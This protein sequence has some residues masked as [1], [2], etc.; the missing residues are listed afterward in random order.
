SRKRMAP[1]SSGRPCKTSARRR[2]SSLSEPLLA[3]LRSAPTLAL[4]RRPSRRALPPSASHSEALPRLQQPAASWPKGN[5]L[6]A[7]P[8]CVRLTQYEAMS[9]DGQETLDRCD[10]CVSGLRVGRRRRRRHDEKRATD[11]GHGHHHEGEGRAR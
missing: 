7:R 2:V 9:Y 11:V 6:P 10:S 8:L 3:L 5:S 4:V 1:P